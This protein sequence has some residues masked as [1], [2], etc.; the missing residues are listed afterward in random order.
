[1]SKPESTKVEASTAE[2]NKSVS[3][4]HGASVMQ[5]SSSFSAVLPP[6]RGISHSVTV[7][8]SSASLKRAAAPDSSSQ[9]GTS[10]N[11]DLLTEKKRRRLEKNR[12][13]ARECRR[14]KREA[15]G[16]FPCGV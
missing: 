7:N 3:T 13:S 1:M 11:G 9:I 10:K 16:R 15:Q 6:G 14:R 12:L 5:S 4:V 2:S 8:N